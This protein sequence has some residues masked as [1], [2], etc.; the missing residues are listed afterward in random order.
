MKIEIK[1]VPE[2]K[3]PYA[4]IHTAS[5]TDEIQ[6]LVAAFETERS[7]II[8]KADERTILLQPKE[9]IMVRVEDEKTIIYTQTKSYTSHKRLYELERQLGKNFIRI[10]K[11]TIVNI[12]EIKSIE[13]SFNGLMMLVMKNQCKDYIS[14]HYLQ[15]FKKT[16]GL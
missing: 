1:L 9:L 16:I 3:E 7:M 5:I 6:E 13:V 8:A 14:R 12:H 11:T 15:E 4:V 2:L 10:S